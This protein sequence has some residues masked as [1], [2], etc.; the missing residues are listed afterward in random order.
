MMLGVSV[1]M[2]IYERKLRFSDRLESKIVSSSMSFIY[3]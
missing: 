1:D 2:M 3:S